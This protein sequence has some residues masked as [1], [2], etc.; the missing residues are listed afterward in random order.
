MGTGQRTIAVPT[1]RHRRTLI[2]RLGSNSLKRLPTARTAGTSVSADRDRDEHAHGARHADGL[3][4]GHPGKAQAQASLRRSSNRNPRRQERPRGRCCS[5]PFPGPRRLD[6]PLDIDRKEDPV[7]GSGRHREGHQQ[8]DGKRRESNN[9]VIGRETRRSPGPI[10]TS[11][12][13]VTNNRRR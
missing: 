6:A 7:I 8:I 4:D 5:R 13:T 10:R 12:P 11:I 2:L 3:E 9:I 1:R